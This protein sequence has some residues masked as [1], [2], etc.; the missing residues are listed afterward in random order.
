MQGVTPEHNFRAHYQYALLSVL[1]V[2]LSQA[3]YIALLRVTDLNEPTLSAA[4]AHSRVTTCPAPLFVCIV[5]SDC[6]VHHNLYEQREKV[7]KFGVLS[8]NQLQEHPLCMPSM[9]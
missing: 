5:F 7:K 3:G 1:Q 6:K 4:W 9:W 8:H 2:V